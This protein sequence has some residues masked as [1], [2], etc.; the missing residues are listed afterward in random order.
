MDNLYRYKIA[1]WQVID[2]DTADLN[3]DLGFSIQYKSRF[4]L[5]GINAPE[6]KEEDAWAAAKQYLESLLS[7]NSPGVIA[8]TIKDRKD[9][10]GRY[11]VDLVT[12]D[13][14][15]LN[16]KMVLAGHAV[17]YYP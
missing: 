3:L 14:E 6:R 9:K 11:L 17:S 13:G 2:G 16:A 10:Y 1:D 15:S 4:R 5:Y 12:S 7:A 8:V